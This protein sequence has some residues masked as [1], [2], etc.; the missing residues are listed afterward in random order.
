MT[1]SALGIDGNSG[2]L[3]YFN[4]QNNKIL[5]DIMWSLFGLLN[6]KESWV[7]NFDDI[8][9]LMFSEYYYSEKDGIDI[10]FRDAEIY[11]LLHLSTE[12]NQYLRK[13]TVV[14]KKDSPLQELVETEMNSFNKSVLMNSRE[15]FY[16]KIVKCQHF[17]WF[18]YKTNCVTYLAHIGRHSTTL[19][20]NFITLHCNFTTSTAINIMRTN[21]LWYTLHKP[22]QNSL[23]DKYNDNGCAV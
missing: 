21:R 8:F 16:D 12:F 14:S 23:F 17:S 6:N 13:T 19:H 10:E 15:I 11:V 2:G 18:F 3:K 4:A 9:L 20:C 5:K 7:I 22:V 1:S